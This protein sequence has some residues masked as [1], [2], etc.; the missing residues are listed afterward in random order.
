MLEAL[1]ALL[2]ERRPAALLLAGDI[3]DRA[4]PTPPAIGLLDGFLSRAVRAAP[5]TA[6]VMIPGNHDSASR[7]AFGSGLFAKA[8]LHVISKVSDSP[9]PVMVRSRRGGSGGGGPGGGEEGC[10]IWALPFMGGAGEGADVP[11]GQAAAFAR[12]VGE[13]RRGIEARARSE[14]DSYNVLLAHCFA[15]GGMPSESERAFVGLAEEVDA[16]LFDG[17]DYAALGHLHRPQAAGRKGRYSGAPLAYSFGEGL[18]VRLAPADGGDAATVRESAAAERGF[19]FVE[20]GPEGVRT[21]LLPHKP[22]RRLVR[23]EAPF[24][25]LCDPNLFGDYREDLVEVSL[26]DS[27]PV[28]EP[29]ERLKGVFPNLL[30]VRQAAF[31]ARLAGGES[32]AVALDGG[33]DPEDPGRIVGDFSAFHREMRGEEADE[34]MLGLFRSM[35]E[36]ASRAAD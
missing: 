23:I 28:L 1:V 24:E 2:V 13:I 21:E 27:T 15:T 32:E 18:R 10:A 20:L 35:V 14:I 8:G 25:K 9:E 16:G 6:I 26:K 4:I 30:S 5:D 17:F 3:Y 29:S 11:R 19:V 33:G 34:A 22:A 7:L 12:A 36:E 31:E